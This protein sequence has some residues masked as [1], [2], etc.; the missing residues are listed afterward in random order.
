MSGIRMTGMNSGLD[1]ESIVQAMVMSYKNKKEKVEKSQTKLEW[2]QEIWKNT[3]SKIYGLYTG[4]DKVRF[5]G[6]YKSKKTTVS[7]NTKATI[8]A[9]SG[10]TN[11][12]QSLRIT[13]LAKAGYLTGGKVESTDGSDISSSSTLSS[14]GI[15]G[16][17][18]FEVEVG[19]NTTT[20][21]VTGDTKIREVVSQLNEAGV[22]ASFDENSGRFFVAAKSTGKA[23][24]FKLKNGDTV[25][26]ALK[27]QSK[28]EDEIKELKQTKSYGQFKSDGSYDED[29]TKRAI[30]SQLREYQNTYYDA[31]EKQTDLEKEKDRLNGLSD[32]EKGD[33]WQTDLDKVNRQ[34]E[35]QEDIIS[36]LQAEIED[37]DL[38]SGYENSIASWDLDKMAED[39]TKTI[40]DAVSELETNDSEGATRVDGQDAEIY[41]N[42]AKF[43]SENNT[44]DVNGLTINATGVT[45]DD[46]ISITTATDVDAVYDKF[47]DFLDQ[48]NSL[49]NELQGL[50][51]AEAAKDYEPLTEDE[52]EEMNDTEIEKWETKIKD[53]L[54]RRDTTLRGV[55]ST[56]TSSMS[57][58]YEV[59]LKDGTTQKMALSSVGVHT[60]GVLNAKTNEQYAYHIDGDEDDSNTSDKTDKLRAF[61]ESDPDAAADLLS[62]VA[63]G[64]YKGLDTKV[65]KT[66]SDNSSAFTVYNDKQMKR[67]LDTYKTSIKEWEQKIEDQEDFYYKKFTAME[68]ALANLNSTQSALGG[69]MG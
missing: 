19:G 29:K 51:N 24:D 25:L 52:K 30:K 40:S 4:L 33:N 20:I 28:T 49:V 68:K 61:I 58:T 18:S 14:L 2:S 32:E 45:G 22:N 38:F 67:E 16:E 41:L 34:L 11:G 44:F 42:G 60:L 23:N 39:V 69:M 50:Y 53:S 54:L 27:L 3:N 56:M 6:N 57:Q 15:E 63:Q 13:Q 62:Q 36:N 7:D 9:G 26:D 12:T 21:N 55:I 65:G 31:L 5:S 8:S 47:K 46:E 64:L 35:E 48:Y 17:A 43:T 66:T 1:T 10:A 59:K 37:S